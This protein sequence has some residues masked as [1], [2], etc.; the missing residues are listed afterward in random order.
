MLTS[1]GSVLAWG[2]NAEGQCNVPAL[3]AG[4]VYTD[5]SC[6]Y[7]HM[8]AV[9]SDGAL[10]AW[11]SNVAGETAVPPLPPVPTVLV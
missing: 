7:T 8:L 1:A 11:G 10:V 9:R 5:V 2:D 3:P 4:V 6:G